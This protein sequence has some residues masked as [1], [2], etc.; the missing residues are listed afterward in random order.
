MAQ[1]SLSS[2]LVIILHADVVDSTSLVQL[3]KQIAHQRIQDSFH[4]LSKAIESYQGQVLE[5]RGDALLA[6]F[7]HAADAVIAALSFQTDHSF[8]VNQLKDDLQPL[9]RIG[10]A[11]GEVVIADNTVTG[12]GVVQAQRI[13]QLAGSGGVCISAVI[14]EALS[15][16]LPFDFQNLGEQSLKGFDHMVHV[17]RVQLRPNQSIPSPELSNKRRSLWKN[18]LALAG[19]IALLLSVTIVTVHQF[20]SPKN[21]FEPA[22]QNRLVFNLP[23]KPSIAVLPF[24]NLS[25]DPNQDFLAI[26][27]SEDIVTSLANQSGLF[28]ISGSTTSKFNGEN[29]TAKEVSE[30]LGVRYILKGNMQR[31]NEKIRINAQL[32]DAIDG[33]FVW[34]DRYD[35]NL[36]DLF[37]V[38]DKIT[39]K[40]IANVG[41]HLEY[42]ESDKARSNET[43]SLDAWLLQR[44]GWR[45]V[46]KLNQQ[47]NIKG[48]KLLQQAIEIDP[49]YAL[50]YA[51]LG[52]A[53]RF[54]YQLHLS[55]DRQS[56]IKKAF[57]LY[58]KALD[59]DPA[60]GLVMA[61]F[62][63]W[64][65]TTGDIEKAVKIASSAVEL[66]PSNYFVHGFYGM[67]LTHSGSV[68]KAIEELELSVR[69][70]PRGPDWVLFKLSEAYLMDGNAKKAVVVAKSLLDRPPS[71]PSNKNIAHINHALALN[72]LGRIEEARGEVS[73]AIQT[74]PKRTVAVWE[75]QRPYSNKEL[76]ENWSSVLKSLGMP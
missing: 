44:E 23:K 27:F 19:V 13:E 61:S 26:G 74:F 34:S 73:S 1:T 66:E 45:L 22:D 5:L 3:D 33:R 14:H 65:L 30:A 64:Y 49:K 21:D 47:D 56:A 46:M 53:Y 31:D 37:S 68:D 29:Y 25:G 43:D 71:S 32:I 55:N 18:P 15:K 54:D 50:A 76:Q 10:I 69:L 62:A 9:V 40:I 11:M 70:S 24:D 67:A 8:I 58:Q 17:Y 7:E 38:R 36:T 35:R 51:N 57:D 59:I 28:V 2:K 75:K 72:E 20:Y 63:S 12:A 39:L 4:Q 41:A 52:T 16:Q 42:G 48:R 6:T 60:N